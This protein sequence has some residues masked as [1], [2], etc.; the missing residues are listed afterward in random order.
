MR[1]TMQNLLNMNKQN[2]MLHRYS[3]DLSDLSVLAVGERKS[4]LKSNACL[5]TVYIRILKYTHKYAQIFSNTPNRFFYPTS[6]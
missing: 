4:I 2:Y 3:L 1:V 6:K 5:R